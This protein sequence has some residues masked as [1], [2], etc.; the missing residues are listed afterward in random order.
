VNAPLRR[1]GIVVLILFGLLFANLNWVQAYKAD[2]YR[3]DDHNGRVQISDYERQRGTITVGKEGKSVAISVETNGTLTYLRTYPLKGLYA[4]VVGYKPVNLAATGIERA[5][6]DFLSG[7]ADPLNRLTEMFTGQKI[8][9]GNINLTLLPGAQST[10]YNELVK[11]RV[12][13][14]SGAVVALDPRT[15]AILSMVS[16]PSFDPNPLA[17]H[18]FAAASDAFQQLDQDPSKPLLNRALSETFP[19]GSTFKVI[20]SAAALENGRNPQTLIPAGSVYN[21]PGTSSAQIKN[22]APSICPGAQVTLI[23]ALTES[24]NTGFAQLGVALGGDAIIQAARDFGF[25]Q[26]VT[27]E[28]DGNRAMKS[29]ASETGTMQGPNGLDPAQVAQSSIGQRDVRMTPLQGAMIAAAVANNGS[30]M[31][32]YLIQSMQKADLTPTYT[33]DPKQ[34]RQSCDS[35]VAAS[36]RQMMESVVKNGTGSRAA[37][38]GFTVG[39]KTGTAQNEITNDHGWFIGYEMKDGQPVAAIAVLLESAGPGGSSEAARIAGQVLQAIN[40]EK[41]LK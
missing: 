38:D 6:D 30:Q 11:N 41:G 36:L 9:G 15:G 20:V 29:A 37:V 35:S 34:L 18:D 7:Q 23:E 13:A 25:G 31:K 1:V 16:T 33:A 2:E 21:L 28:G 12:G 40:T 24:C 39:G 5:E 19:P 3:T 10:A 8:G 26:E 4:H 22:A 17:S 27:L 32:P 14:N